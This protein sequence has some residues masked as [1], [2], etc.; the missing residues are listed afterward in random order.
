M[1]KTI[2]TSPSTKYTTLLV[3][4]LLLH[5]K[6]Y[7]Q[8]VLSPSNSI[9][10][11]LLNPF[12]TQSITPQQICIPPSIVYNLL[13]VPMLVKIIVVYSRNTRPPA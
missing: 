13:V 12:P 8:H 2:L 3:T 7:H 9:R 6:A 4:I 10:Y 5:N 1:S 11:P